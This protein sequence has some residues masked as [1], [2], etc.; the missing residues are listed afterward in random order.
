M[1]SIWRAAMD[2]AVERRCSADGT[3]ASE[4]GTVFGRSTTPSP[5]QEHVPA[6]LGTSCSVTGLPIPPGPLPNPNALLPFP[7][8]NPIIQSCHIII[9]LSRKQMCYC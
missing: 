8:D 4:A 5:S 9:L 6:R 2:S 3:S 1:N 7:T